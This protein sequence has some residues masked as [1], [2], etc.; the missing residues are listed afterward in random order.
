VPASPSS[1]AS[2][3]YRLETVTS[4]LTCSSS[5]L[6]PE[7]LGQLHFY[8]NVVD[9]L[10]RRPEHGDGPTIGILPA[11]DRSGVVVGYALR[12]YDTPLV[13]STYTTHRA[14]PRE[15]RDV[16]P[17]PDELSGV[18]EQWRR[19]N[20]TIASTAG[21]ASATLTYRDEH[22]EIEPSSS[23]RNWHERCYNSSA[24]PRTATH[25]TRSLDRRDCVH[26]PV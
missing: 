2:T 11:A 24:P 22:G 12:G 9:D 14:L 5:T 8:V 1:A 6:G 20:P 23:A 13:V 17:S 18:V 3:D 19:R 25:W 15:V 10:L 26:Y 4:S 16:L 7:H 21:A